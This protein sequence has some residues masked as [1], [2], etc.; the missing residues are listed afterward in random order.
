MFG[1][2]KQFFARVDWR[3]ALM[4]GPRHSFTDEQWQR[5]APQ[6][7]IS[8]SVK[9]AALV[10]AV[11]TSAMLV[12]QLPAGVAGPT[13]LI[14]LA[15]ALLMLCLAAAIWRRP[16]MKRLYIAY[17]LTS[18][19]AGILA[20]FTMSY[21]KNHGLSEIAREVLMRDVMLG[22]LFSF[23]IWVVAMWRNEFLA[24][25][26]HDEDLRA[27]AAEAARKLSSAQ[28]QPHFLFNSL[29]SLQHWVLTK[30]DRAAPLLASLTAY[31]RATLPLFERPLLAVGEEAEAARRYLEVM[32][33]RLGERLRFS[34]DIAPEAASVQLPPGVLLTLVE[35]AVEHG[36]QP[37][38]LGGEVRVQARL[39]PGGELLLEVLDDGPGLPPLA[40]VAEGSLGLHNSRLR[41]QQAFGGRAALKLANRAEGGCCAA[42]QLSGHGQD[43]KPL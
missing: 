17:G 5:L 7:A 43:Q 20:G 26:L 38:L 37:S 41:L 40:P 25:W 1:A 28:I 10:N 36:V 11:A 24:D 8:P 23:G 22:I 21:L 14:F 2:L 4:L 9:V 6:V 32:Q 39:L 42:V 33:A 27:Q 19:P 18:F 30:D 12:L 35:N 16:T 29:A 13:F 34:L 3:M 15:Q 31:L